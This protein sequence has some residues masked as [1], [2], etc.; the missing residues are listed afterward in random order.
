VLCLVLDD[1]DV[2][3]FREG[4]LRTGFVAAA[5]LENFGYRQ[6]TLFFRFVGF[7]KFLAGEKAWGRMKRKGFQK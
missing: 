7:I 3:S 1:L 2:V 5:F 6:A 4:H